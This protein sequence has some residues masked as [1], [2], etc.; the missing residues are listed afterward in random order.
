M[1]WCH[2]YNASTARD[3]RGACFRRPDRLEVGRRQRGDALLGSCRSGRHPYGVERELRRLL[4]AEAIGERPA[5]CFKAESSGRGS[6]VCQPRNLEAGRRRHHPEYRRG[7]GCEYARRTGVAS[8]SLSEL[9]LG[10]PPR[11]RSLGLQHRIFADGGATRGTQPHRGDHRLAWS[12]CSGKRAGELYGP[13]GFRRKPA[14][15]ARVTHS[16]QAASGWQRCIEQAANEPTLLCRVERRARSHQSIDQSAGQTGTGAW[17]KEAVA[18][19]AACDVQLS[20]AAAHRIPPLAPQADSIGL[21][22]STP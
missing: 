15:G 17:T 11:R 22:A 4:G 14:R 20:S 6:A 10:W 21:L 2:A 16:T 9:V 7:G 12:A 5:V 1:L 13:S 18:S 19:S 3:S 8:R